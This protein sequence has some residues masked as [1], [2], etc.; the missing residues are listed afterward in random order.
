MP[1]P[2][3]IEA[4]LTAIHDRNARVEADKA[5]ETSWTRRLVIAAM[6]YVI[7]LAWLWVIKNSSPWLNAFIPA[8]GYVLSTLSLP[9]VKAWWV[10]RR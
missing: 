5:W 4:E 7:A 9:A 10:K 8:V 3:N 6:T 1:D 2:I